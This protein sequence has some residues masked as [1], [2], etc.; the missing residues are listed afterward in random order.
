ML[1]S[2]ASKRFDDFDGRYPRRSVP[3]PQEGVVMG[4]RFTRRQAL[5]GAGGA[6]AAGIAL[7]ALLGNE[8][9]AAATELATAKG[10]AKDVRVRFFAGGDAGDAFASIVYRGAQ[11]AQAD[12]GCK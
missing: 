2:P 9:A 3:S 11:Y 8:A 4:R 12:L 6:L 10:W 1:H 5:Q 7:P